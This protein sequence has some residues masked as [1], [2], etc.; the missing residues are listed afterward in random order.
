LDTRLE[1]GQLQEIAAVQWQILN[2]TAG[3]HPAYGMRIVTNLRRAGL[4]GY[5]LPGIAEAEI[6][7]GPGRR[8]RFHGRCAVH[9]R[10]L[11]RSHR[12]VIFS[13]HECREAE[14][15][16]LRSGFRSGDFGSEVH[17]C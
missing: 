13:R 2:F 6:E 5:R 12:H 14:I 10:E 15:P 7:I 17:H 11:V 9:D 1:L 3:D 4:D 16:L 8:S